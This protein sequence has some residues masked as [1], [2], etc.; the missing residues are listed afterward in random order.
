VDSKWNAGLAAILKLS[1]AGAVTFRTTESLFLGMTGA[2][3]IA[4][5]TEVLSYRASSTPD[6]SKTIEEALSA[7]PFTLVALNCTLVHDELNATLLS[8]KTIAN[9]S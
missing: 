8:A 1:P 9:I 3:Q 7:R 6:I 4:F 2:E 5:T